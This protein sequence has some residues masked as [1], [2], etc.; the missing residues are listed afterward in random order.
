MKFDAN[1]PIYLQIMDDF[2]KNIVAGCYKSGDKI[3]SVRDLAVAYGVNPNTVQRALSEL[4][5]VHMVY[6]ERTSGRFI[7]KDETLIETLKQVYA[8]E[9]MDHCIQELKQLGYTNQ[10]IIARIKGRLDTW[11]V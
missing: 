4:E 11:K 5:R 2:K 10:E 7:T 1:M 3:P 6:S 9:Q 8:D